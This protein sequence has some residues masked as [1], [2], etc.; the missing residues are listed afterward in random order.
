M[1]IRTGILLLISLV[2]TSVLFA[3]LL[4]TLNKSEPQKLTVVDSQ[5]AD[6]SYFQEYGIPIVEFN[7]IHNLALK[8][9]ENKN[10]HVLD[11]F[12]HGEARIQL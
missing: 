6:K 2:I 5:L 3:Y 8:I 4:L 7:S 10:I 11:I 9:Q 12:S 1:K